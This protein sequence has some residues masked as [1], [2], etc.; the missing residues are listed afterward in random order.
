MGKIR[1]YEAEGIVVRFDA[2]RCIHAEECVHGLDSVFDAN[3]R[4]WIDATAATPDEIAAVIHKCPTG[5]LNYERTDGGVQETPG[6]AALSLAVDG[7]LYVAG[8]VPIMDHGGQVVM[9]DSRVAL[10]R[11][12]ASKNKPYCDD[13]H[14]EMG[15]KSASEH[16]PTT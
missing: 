6:E 12:G 16:F 14:H 8:G 11:C 2:K 4:P 10:C 9:S 1:E 13:S 7:P 15:F 3:R 5:A